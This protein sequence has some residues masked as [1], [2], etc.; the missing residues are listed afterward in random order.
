MGTGTAWLEIVLNATISAATALYTASCIS[1]F[2]AA[3]VLRKEFNMA[4]RRVAIVACAHRCCDR[5]FV[6]ATV[7]KSTICPN[8]STHGIFP[9]HAAGG[10]F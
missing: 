10:L 2:V 9:L 5:L 4:A 7:V 6:V 3:W 8:I 1:H